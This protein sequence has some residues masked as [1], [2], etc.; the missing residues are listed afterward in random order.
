MRQMKKKTFLS[1]DFK[2][3]YF[4][5]GQT[6]LND[7]ELIKLSKNNSQFQQNYQKKYMTD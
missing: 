1:P 2:G 4:F 6:L 5:H 7:L 3:K